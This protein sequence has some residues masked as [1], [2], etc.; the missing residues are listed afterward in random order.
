MNRFLQTVRTQTIGPSNNVL[1]WGKHLMAFKGKTG[2][3]KK[4]VDII[5]ELVK[6]RRLLNQEL[7]RQGTNRWMSDVPQIPSYHHMIG[8][9]LRSLRQYVRGARKGR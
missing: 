3:A 7:M 2:K 6:A 5:R 9:F 1:S 4:P 8:S